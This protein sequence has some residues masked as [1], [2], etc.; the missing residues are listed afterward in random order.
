MT[1]SDNSNPLAGKA[2]EIMAERGITPLPVH[3]S[4]W[5]HYV[6]GENKPLIKEVNKAIDEDVPFDEGLHGYLHQKYIAPAEMSQQQTFHDAKQVLAQVLSVIGNFSGESENYQAEMDTHITTLEN[7]QGTEE[8]GSIVHQIIESTKSL[9]MRSEAMHAKL[10]SSR[11]EVEGLKQHLVEV[12]HEAQRDYLT[13]V[14]NRNAFNKLMDSLTQLA[15]EQG[16]PLC[17]LMI[18]I[19]FFKNFNDTHGHLIGDEVLKTVA[20]ILTDTLKGRDIVARFGGEEFAVMLPAT[21]LDGAMAVAEH[22]RAAI[23]SKE[24][25]RKDTGETVGQI[26]VSIGAAAYRP[27][28]DTL[29]TLIR[30]ADEA[31]YISKKTGRNRVTREDTVLEEEEKA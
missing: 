30:R 2:M 11:Q 1:S 12:T 17:L 8:L 29:P 4:V 7:E 27:G 5:Y 6:S 10:E 18:D 28:K 24:L 19:D 31:L 21:P 14:F 9:K 25:K 20:K 22:L 26:T 16:A 3:Y 23:A 13:G 15:E